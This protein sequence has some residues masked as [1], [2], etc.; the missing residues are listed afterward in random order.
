MTLPFAPAPV[1]PKD[2]NRR[3]F[4]GG[5]DA[6]I[7][8]GTDEAALVRHGEKSGARRNH[9]ITRITSSSSLGRPLSPS[10]DAGTRKRPDK[11]SR[12]SRAGFGIP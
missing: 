10:T 9:R 4:V 5:S 1:Y 11:S 6:R 7:V 12:T 8:M 3:S 2:T